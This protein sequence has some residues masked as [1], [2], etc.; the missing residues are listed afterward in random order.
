VAYASGGDFVPLLPALGASRQ[1]VRVLVAERPWTRLGIISIAGH[2]GYELVAG[3]AVPLAPHVGVRYRNQACQTG[4]VEAIRSGKCSDDSEHGTRVD[5]GY[6]RLL[7]RH[8]PGQA[9]VEVSDGT[10]S[11]AAAQPLAVALFRLRS[12]RAPLV[13]AWPKRGMPGSE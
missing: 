11:I 6:L 3:V 13:K 9:V 12:R 10:L 7:L 1:Q 5:R 2:L 4:R 8:R